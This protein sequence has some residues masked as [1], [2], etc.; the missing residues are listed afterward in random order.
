MKKGFTLIELLVVIAIIAILA[1]ILFPVFAQA[2]EKARQTSCLS[3]CKQI[4]TAL[5]LYTDDYDETLPMRSYQLDGWNDD[6][7]G[8]WKAYPR[9]QFGYQ[10]DFQ[11]Y[12]HAG[13]GTSWIFW[14][15]A[16]FPYV[17]N[18]NVFLCP[19]YSVKSTIRP[20]SWGISG[21]IPGYG[22]N[23]FLTESQYLG[24]GSWNNPAVIGHSTSSTGKYAIP[25]RSLNDLKNTAE[26]VFC[27]DTG[28]Y[29]N[30]SLCADPVTLITTIPFYLDS[31]STVGAEQLQAYGAGTTLNNANR[32]LTGANFTFCD[33]HAKYY[34]RSQGPLQASL[35]VNGSKAGDKMWNPDIQ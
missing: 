25:S 16:I 15:D 6:L 7:S 2:R 9:Y 17:K 11:A 19:S 12:S 22:F 24:F 29:L 31:V 18:L 27:S 26:T 35:P 34:K 4:G 32:H 5:Q 10:Y 1:A 23:H 3:N 20:S 14:D 30:T 28:I 33:G 8:F 13:Y 21:R